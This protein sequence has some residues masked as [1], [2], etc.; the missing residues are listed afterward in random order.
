MLGPKYESYYKTAAFL[1]IC[2][3]LE[4]ISGRTETEAWNR[5]R[6]KYLFG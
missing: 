5:L 6:M 4:L 2:R 1:D 3:K